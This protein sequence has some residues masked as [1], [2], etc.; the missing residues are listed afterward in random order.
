MSALW[1]VAPLVLVLVLAASWYALELAKRLDRLHWRLLSTRDALDRLT[2]RRASEARLVVA[3]GLL[4]AEGA[5][6]IDRAAL[7]CLTGEEALFVMDDLDRRRDGLHDAEVDEHAVAERNERESALTR[8]IRGTL[9]PEVVDRV[10]EAPR[11]PELLDSLE[12]ACYRVQLAR[13][14]HNL[15]VTQVLHLRE[16]PW[17]RILHLY[18]RA[19]VPATI[20]FD[21]ATTSTAD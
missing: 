5:H 14:M 16:N 8:A 12:M 15:D 19:P 9:T 10:R 20:D 7:A 21:D 18:G 13:S 1:W 3:S 6:R 17:V 11:G 4:P 2:V